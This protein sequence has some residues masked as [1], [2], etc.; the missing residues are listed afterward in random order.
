MLNSKSLESYIYSAPKI[1]LHIHLEGS[2]TPS[3][4]KKHNP[5]IHELIENFRASGIQSPINFFQCFEKIHKALYSPYHYYLATLNFLD[6]L[7]RER[8][9]YV[10]FTW[11]PGA[12]WEFHKIEPDKAFEAIQMAIEERRAFIQARVLI[13]IIRNQPIS[14]AHLICSWLSKKKSSFIVGIN[15]G[16]IESSD[17]LIPFHGLFQQLKAY[18]YKLTLHLGETIGEAELLELARLMKP[19]RIG[20]ATC[21]R[22]NRGA[23]QLIDSK[24][25]IEACPSSNQKLGYLQRNQKHPVFVFPRLKASLNTD[26]RSFFCST[27]SGEILTLMRQGDLNLKQLAKMQVQAVKDRF[28]TAFSLKIRQIQTF[29]LRLIA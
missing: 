4:W 19:D 6:Q 3:F 5:Q 14:I 18:G 9:L 21:L 16:G 1:E 8:I 20:H 27:L 15:S 29:W 10:E 28:E 7:I 26:D 25:H 11:A 2:L 23:I 24:I 17:D 12:I 22:T 13:D